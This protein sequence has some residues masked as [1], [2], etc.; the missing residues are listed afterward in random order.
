M[1][2]QTTSKR[3]RVQMR[4]EE[5]TKKPLPNLTLY[6][7]GLTGRLRF[8]SPANPLQALAPGNATLLRG[9]R[10]RQLVVPPKHFSRL[11]SVLTCPSSAMAEYGRVDPRKGSGKADWLCANWTVW[12]PIQPGAGYNRATSEMSRI[13]HRA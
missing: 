8:A 10:V 4:F 5:G 11:E 2:F 9:T 12:P 3:P 1:P 13:P 6:Q 7:T